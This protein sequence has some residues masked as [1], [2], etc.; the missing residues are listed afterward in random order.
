MSYPLSSDGVEFRISNA[1]G[2][3]HTN[4]NEITGNNED[5]EYDSDN[6]DMLGLNQE[7]IKEPELPPLTVTSQTPSTFPSQFYELMSILHPQGTSQ[8]SHL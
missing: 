8:E 7:A 5:L 2:D 3:P 4:N 1:Q 6:I